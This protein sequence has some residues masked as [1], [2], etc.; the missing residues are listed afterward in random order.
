MSN[1]LISTESRF[2]VN[3]KALRKAVED[4]LSEQKIKTAVEVSI[5]IVGDRKMAELN[6]KYRK[7]TGTTPI[8]TFSLSDYFSDPGSERVNDPGSFDQKKSFVTPPDDILHLGDIIISYP[9]TVLM[10]ASENKMVDA[11][12]SE[13]VTHGLKNLFGLNSS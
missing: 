7:L 10:A 5:S 9:Q 2:P 6:K 3:R 13:F 1:I 11:V 4:F 12:L 8:L